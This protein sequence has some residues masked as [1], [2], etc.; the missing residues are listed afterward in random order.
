MEELVEDPW[1]NEVGFSHEVSSVLDRVLDQSESDGNAVALLSEW[2]AKHQP[3]LFGRIAAKK[4]LITFSVINEEQLSDCDEAVAERIQAARREWTRLG[5]EGNASAFMVIVRS[6]RLATALPGPTVKSIASRICSLYLQEEV[7]PDTVYLDRIY[8][9][10][11][12]SRRKTWEWVTGVNYFSAQGDGRW[13]QDHRIPT[14]MAFSANSVGHMARAGRL[15]R[16]MRDLEDAMGTAV[17]DFATPNVDSLEKALEL[18]MRTIALASDGP[19]GKA[20]ALRPLRPDIRGMPRC[21]VEL[22]HFLADKDYC[23]YVGQYHTDYTLP[24]E[25]FLPDVLR[26]TRLPN[27]D[28]DLTYL[29]DQSLDNPDFERAGRGRMIR[30][31]SVT[32]DQTISAEAYRAQKRSRGEPNEVD[33]GQVPRLRDALRNH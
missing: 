4:G 29:F 18:A 19:S 11:A 13:W 33:I 9:E 27:H 32:S 17:G 14:G 2:L 28:L 23:S 22:P 25:Y 16:A 1:R 20:T 8:L 5:F 6:R 10:Q 21:P 7:A 31:P 3:C 30:E 24:S 15:A 26:P 12:G